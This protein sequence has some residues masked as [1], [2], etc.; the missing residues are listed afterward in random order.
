MEKLGT[1]NGVVLVE[2]DDNGNVKREKQPTP[3]MASSCSCS[4][5]RKISPIIP[6]F[7][8]FLVVSSSFCPVRSS[9]NGILDPKNQTFRPGEESQKLKMMRKRLDE[10]NKPASPDG[11]I[12]DCVLL[13]HQPAFDHPRLKGKKPLDPPERPSGVNGN[14]MGAD[15]FQLWSMSGESCPEG[16]IPIR[17][18]EADMLR[19]SSVRRFGRKG[20]RRRVRRDSTSNGHEHA[21]GYVSG[22]QYYGAKASINVWTPRVSN[23]YEFSLS[24]IWVISDQPGAIW[25]Q[26]SQNLYLLDRSKAWELVAGIR[27]RCPS[28]ILASL[29]IYS[30]TGSCEH[31]S[32]RWG[33]CEFE[34]GGFPHLDRNGS[35][36]FAGE[37]FG[38]ASYFRN[39]HVDWDNNLI[40]LSNLR[41][42]A[43]HPNCYDIQG[44][45]NRVW[46]ITFTM[47]DQEEMLNALKDKGFSKRVGH[48]SLLKA[49]LQGI[50]E[51]L[52]LARRVGNRFG[53]ME[54]RYVPR[55]R[56]RVA[57]CVCLAHLVVRGSS[58]IHV[59]RLPRRLLFDF[60]RDDYSFCEMIIVS[61]R[62]EKVM[63]SVYP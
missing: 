56:N 62:L 48:C 8:F 23:Q 22:E 2:E 47:E 1:I 39:M 27:V 19:A 16:T 49:E 53:R 54:F 40:P 58:A 14:G 3:D 6:F 5:C 57:D 13:H 9:E 31:G 32:I 46:A 52:S 20:P 45:I 28:R 24:Q 51:G 50:Y 37:G 60:R 4:C 42:L 61:T 21:V 15:D 33:S 63:M 44:G 10:I 41:V 12:I 11:D 17:T 59:H 43:D 34:G 35:G 18:A 29:L 36:H 25:G 26:L 7:V 38:K 30:P 55:E